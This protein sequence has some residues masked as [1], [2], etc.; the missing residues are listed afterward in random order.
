MS[1]WISLNRHG[2]AVKVEAFEDGGTYMLG[3]STEADLNVTYNYSRLF[4]LSLHDEIAEGV[5]FADWLTGKT[6]REAIPALQKAVARLGTDRDKNYW[7]P[8]P[9]NAGAALATLLRWAEAHPDA[10][11]DVH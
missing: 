3:G 8:T 2:E 9:G 5:R 6:G 7:A 10:V 11:F 4:Y 1:W